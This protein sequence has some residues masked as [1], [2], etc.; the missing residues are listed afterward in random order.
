MRKQIVLI[1]TF[2][3]M[4]SSPLLAE[5]G[6]N[7]KQLYNQIGL[8]NVMPYELFERGINGYNKIDSKKRAVITFIDFSKISSSERIY[9]V[10][11]Q[12]KSLLYKTYVSHGQ[13]SGGEYAKYFS[14]IEGSLKSS[15]GFFLTKDTYHGRNGYSLRLKGLEEN[16]NDKAMERY[17]VMHGAKYSNPSTIEQNGRLGRSWGCPALPEAISKEIIDV[18]KDGSVLFIY[19]DNSEYLSKSKYL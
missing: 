9:V 5:V 2:I 13:N 18:I 19:A 14:N 4:I 1:V 3:F 7:T 12:N 15:L 10:D 8:E 6:V 11:I 16:I 17:I